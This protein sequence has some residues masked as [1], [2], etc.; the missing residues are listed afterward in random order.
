MR[1]F[2]T[3]L[4]AE[5][6]KKSLLESDTEVSIALEPELMR[7]KIYFYAFWNIHHKINCL[8]LDFAFNSSHLLRQRKTYALR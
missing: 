1:H 3:A 4:D 2:S 5:P 8:N 7:T 6:Q